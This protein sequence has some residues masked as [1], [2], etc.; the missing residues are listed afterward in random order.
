MPLSSRMCELSMEEALEAVLTLC[1]G[2]SP[3]RTSAPPASAEGLKTE[4]V[5]D[6]GPS[7]LESFAK[8]SPDSCW[9]KTSG[10]YSQLTLEGGLELFS[11]TWPRS[12]MMLNGACALLPT[13]APPIGESEFGSL[14]GDETFTAPPN[15][16]LLP[17][18][19]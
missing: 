7:S 19:R 5:A 12:G 8:L 9:L 4:P 15:G 2:D 6:C 10:G 17:P 14:P 1:A 16:Q 13:S 3:A 18:G 11:G